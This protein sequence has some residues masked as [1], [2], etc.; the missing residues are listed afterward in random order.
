MLEKGKVDADALALRLESDIEQAI[1]ASHPNTLDTNRHRIL[2]KPLTDTSH[3]DPATLQRILDPSAP[4]PVTTTPLH[5]Q[6]PPVTPATERKNDDH[7]V[8][9]I[10]MAQRDR[11]RAV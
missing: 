7:S 2:D 8:A 4:V 3:N 11:L 1:G 6:S 5:A 9:T 10:V